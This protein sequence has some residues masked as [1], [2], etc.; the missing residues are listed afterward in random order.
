MNWKTATSWMPCGAVLVGLAV[1]PLANAYDEKPAPTTS[2]SG[3][4]ATSKA[5]VTLK[6]LSWEESM[7]LVQKHKGKIVVL[8]VWSTSCEPCMKEF[9]NLVKLHKEQGRDVACISVSVDYAGSKKKPPAYYEKEVLNFLTQQE[10]TFENVLCNQPS[11]EVFEKI[12]LASIPAVYV[13]GRDGKLVKRFDSDSSE[14]VGTNDEA[15]TYAD[16]NK[17]VGSLLKKK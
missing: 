6:T 13:F 3:K 9:P 15:F 2:K 16:V 4:R 8:D 10:A 14:N 7:A 17:L 1:T 12:D 11:D 5:E